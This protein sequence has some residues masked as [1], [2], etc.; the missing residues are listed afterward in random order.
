[1]PLPGPEPQGGLTSQHYGPAGH[2]VHHWQNVSSSLL[3]PAC[4][5]ASGLIQVALGLGAAGAHAARAVTVEG[6]PALGFDSFESRPAEKTL[7][8]KSA[9]DSLGMSCYEP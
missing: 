8:T 9:D 5:P 6:V 4:L 2:R 3:S 7:A 1:M